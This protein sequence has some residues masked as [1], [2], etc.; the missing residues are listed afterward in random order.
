MLEFFARRRLPPA[1]RRCLPQKRALI[2]ERFLTCPERFE[3]VGDARARR[4]SGT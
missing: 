3:N 4:R 1:G 2:G